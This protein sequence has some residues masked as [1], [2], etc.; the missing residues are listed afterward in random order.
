MPEQMKQ[1][2]DRFSERK[3]VFHH[4][5]GLPIAKGLA[6]CKLIVKRQTLTQNHSTA[7]TALVGGGEADMYAQTCSDKCGRATTTLTGIWRASKSMGDYP[8]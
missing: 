8:S 5:L 3:G 7:P 1:G 4:T 6:H 2:G